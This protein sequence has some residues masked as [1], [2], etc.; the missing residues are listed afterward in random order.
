MKNNNKSKSVLYN[1]IFFGSVALGVFA[2]L[3]TY[4]F[5]SITRATLGLIT[6]ISIV[7]FT[8]HMTPEESVKELEDINALGKRI[9]SLFIRVLL[10]IWAITEVFGQIFLFFS[11]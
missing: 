1:I 6:I 7:Y 2:G 3:N 9:I 10:L 5:K 8:I 4:Q 11:N